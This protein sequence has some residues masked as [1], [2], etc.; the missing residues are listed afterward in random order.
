MPPPFLHAHRPGNATDTA[1][2]KQRAA[3]GGDASLQAV[4]ESKEDLDALVAAINDHGA[5]ASPEGLKDARSARDAI[6]HRRKKAAGQEKREADRLAQAEALLW[7]L[8][9][10]ND[11]SELQEVIVEAQGLAGVAESLDAEVVVA[12]ERLIDLRAAAKT[13]AI[14]DQQDLLEEHA[15]ASALLGLSMA[16]ELDMKPSA[17]EDEKDSKPSADEVRTKRTGARELRRQSAN[18]RGTSVWCASTHP[19]LSCWCHA[20]TSASAE[21]ALNGPRLAS[22][23]PSAARQWP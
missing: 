1:A 2:D 11:I 4:L 12:Q 8:M 22:P 7:L 23:A 9:S 17:D 15:V 14:E 20:D 19:A 18:H 16:P 21:P 5:H 6:K 13:S 3:E 10:Q